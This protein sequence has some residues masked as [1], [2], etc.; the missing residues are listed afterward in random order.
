[1][2][3][4]S[5]KL[6][7]FTE[8]VIETEVSLADNN[9]IMLEE[10]INQLLT[11]LIEIKKT[12]NR[13]YIIGNGGSAA[14]A[15]HAVIDFINIGKISAHTLQDPAILTCM[16]NDYGYENVYSS[17][18]QQMVNHGDCLIAISSSGESQNIIN[19]VAVAKERGAKVVTLSGFDANNR[20]KNIGDL[21]FWCNSDDYG[22]VEIAHQ[23]ILHHIADNL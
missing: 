1:M 19:G 16:A 8:T 10:G 21:N 22:S 17:T 9:I 14:V 2:L 5:E 13:L 15:S 7:N 20:L 18:I 3:N 6:K 4:L 23:F 12:N 11:L